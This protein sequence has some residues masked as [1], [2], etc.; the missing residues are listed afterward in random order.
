M[1]D[2]TPQHNLFGIYIIR[3]VIT[4][5]VYI[6]S[7][8]QSFKLR[9]QA[10]IRE[11]RRNVH[12]NQRLQRAWLKYGAD[13]FV[14]DTLEIVDDAN[15]VIGREQ[16]HLDQYFGKNCYNLNPNAENSMGRVTSDETKAKL[17]AISKGKPK[18]AET[19][20][21]MSEGSKRKPYA[22]EETRLKRRLLKLGKTMPKEQREK[23]AATMTGQ[24]RPESGPK[25]A[26]AQMGNERS[27]KPYPALISPDGTLYPAGNNRHKFCRTHGLDS[28]C[29]TKIIK[30]K[31][32]SHKGWRLA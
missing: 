27:A 10:H 32:T 26:R 20:R 8:T 9:W 12:D 30:G 11:L 25:I 18:S 29:L 22:T 16:Y 4:G 6:G 17:S 3:N 24:K 19:R 31:Y 7:T 15:S 23:I 5:D 14:F 1:V 28:S 21:R 2:Y 13:A